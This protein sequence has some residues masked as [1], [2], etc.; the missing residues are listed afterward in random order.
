MWFKVDDKFHS[1]SKVR[2]VLADDPAALALWVVAG[3]WSSDN[4]EDGFV[5]DHQLPWL[6][7]A[8]ADALAQ[9]LV[10]ARLWKR[11]RGGYQFHDF[12][13]WN[14][15]AAEVRAKQEKRSQAGRKGGIRSAETRSSKANKRKV[16]AIEE[17]SS[18]RSNSDDLGAVNGTSEA[19]KWDTEPL[20]WDDIEANASA[21]A[22]ANAQ[23]N[24]KQKRTPT[25]PDPNPKNP[26]S[27]DGSWEGFAD[28]WTA[29][30]PRR[31]SSKADALKAYTKA[32]KEG[33]DPAA[34]QTAAEAYASERRGKDQQYTAHAATWLNG[35]R[36]ETQHHVEAPRP[37]S[38]WEN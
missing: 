10:A 30:P 25:R 6:I 33:A 4:L 8:G 12:S 14:P 29:Y 18:E 22:T 32:I 13:Q 23:A 26:S 7:P 35:K 28:F 19:P 37:R 1:H 20:N 38:L 24:A 3:S 34:I 27:P 31:N 5:P 17:T 11:V 2:K 21:P 16:R 9:K 15:T 36:W